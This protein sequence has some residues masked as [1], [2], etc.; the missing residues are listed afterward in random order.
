M[1]G[2]V[3]ARNRDRQVADLPVKELGTRVRRQPTYVDYA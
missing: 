3:P 1:R 2:S